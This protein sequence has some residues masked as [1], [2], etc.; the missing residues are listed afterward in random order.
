MG[1]EFGHMYM[2]ILHIQII[3]FKLFFPLSSFTAENALKQPHFLWVK[4]RF[5]EGIIRFG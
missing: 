4:E 1:L 5:L 3:K 2:F